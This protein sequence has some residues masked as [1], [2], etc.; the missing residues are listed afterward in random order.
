MRRVEGPGP[1]ARAGAAARLAVGHA[2]LDRDAE[3]L[4]LARVRDVG[5]LLALLL[6]ELLEH[7]GA[8]LARDDLAAAVALARA[9]GRPRDRL[10]A[11]HLRARARP[12][13]SAYRAPHKAWRSTAAPPR[14][15]RR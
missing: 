11:Q 8:E 15:R 1:G 2:G 13:P 12:A 5:A 4:G 3:R 7:A 14:L 9:L 10:V 6:L